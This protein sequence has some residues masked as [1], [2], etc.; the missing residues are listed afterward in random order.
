[1]IHEIED[2]FIEKLW[3]EGFLIKRKIKFEPK[4][5]YY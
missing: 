5:G 2:P 1:M 4:G 3:E